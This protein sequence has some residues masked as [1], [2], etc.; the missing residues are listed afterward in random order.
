MAK[1]NYVKTYIADVELKYMGQAYQVNRHPVTFMEAEHLG[2]SYV[3]RVAIWEGFNRAIAVHTSNC[4]NLANNVAYNV[5]GH[6]FFL[7]DGIEMNNRFAYNLA[8]ATRAS[9]SLLNSD[10]TPA[11]FWITNPRNN[12]IGN[13][14]A[15]SEMYGFWFDLP[16]HPTG[17]SA[18]DDVCPPGERL[19][20]F[21]D[22]VA[23][24]NGRYGL[25]LFSQHIPRQF[26]CKAISEEP[27]EGAADPE[28]DAFAAN[29]PIPAKYTDFLSFKNQRAGVIAE[30][31]GAVQFERITTADNIE[32]GIEISLPGFAP[33]KDGWV[34]GARI[35][36]FTANA[37]DMTKYGSTRGIV[38]PQKDSF[39]FKNVK[40]INF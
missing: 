35:F 38:T 12:F 10:Q 36:G 13:H 11:S 25:R 17:Q 2:G 15:G 27:A 5:M 30:R 19:G 32:A 18:T 24:S 28:G 6:N 3:E 1:G 8:I 37:G 22:N 4:M 31:I 7:Q 20:S 34:D 40:F 26:P 23:H 16:D 29:P 14:A 21:K 9:H 39:T 33:L